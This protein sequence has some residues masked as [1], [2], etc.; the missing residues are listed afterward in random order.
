MISW[1]ILK[2]VVAVLLIATIL[3][4]GIS[5]YL[6]TRAEKLVHNAQLSKDY[7]Y[8]V[9]TTSDFRT[10]SAGE[11]IEIVTVPS[12]ITD[13]VILYFPGNWG[14]VGYVL[15]QASAFGT[16]IS[17]AYPGY[18]QSEGVAS[19]ANVYETVDITMQYLFELGYKEEQIVVLGHS[20]G[21]SPSVYAA[22]K[23]PNLKKVV[24]VNT[25]YS[26]EA[27]CQKDYGIFCIFSKDYLNTSQLA[28]NATAK[29]RHFHTPND[30][31]IPLSQGKRLFEMLGSADKKFV[32]IGG[33]H[34][35]FPVQVVLTQE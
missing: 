10:N 11:K 3:W 7:N 18:S 12:A 14:R 6:F 29:I 19:S 15:Q 13:Q 16:V 8:G 9:A 1:G 33:S 35:E 27:M 25:F 2:I 31:L 34:G 17:P 32:E 24:L 22:T 5:Y 21:G 20:L 26:I 4:L 30:E 23:Y 28:P